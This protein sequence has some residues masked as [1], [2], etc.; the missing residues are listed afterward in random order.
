MQA[1]TE[2]SGRK[3]RAQADGLTDTV[4]DSPADRFADALLYLATAQAAD[5]WKAWAQCFAGVLLMKQGAIAAGLS[6]LRT[7]LSAL[8][9]NAFHMNYTAFLADTAEALG[10][11]DEH[12]KGLATIEEAL[13]RA[14]H[15][16]EL[17]CMAELLRIKGALL[18]RTDAGKDD[19]APDQ[20]FL[21]SLDWARRQ[22]AL[23][24]EL[25]TSVSRAQWLR[26]H[27]RIWEARNLLG[28]VCDRFSEG[29]ATADLK[30]ARDLLRELT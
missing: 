11:C 21:E 3:A 14:E 4:T 2:R 16:E 20:H 28:A 6:N 25:R 1:A 17:W 15:N 22:G 8:P 23:A 26:D 19:A 9:L 13:A 27:A 18:L 24:W 12:V 10:C 7:G 30:A 5:P 29:F